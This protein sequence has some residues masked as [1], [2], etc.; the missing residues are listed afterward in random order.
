[1]TLIRKVVGAGTKAAKGAA[2]PNSQRATSI[3]ATENG[4]EP[5][6]GVASQASSHIFSNTYP[7]KHEH[8]LPDRLGRVATDWVSANPGTAACLAGAGIGVTLIAA[9]MAI[10]LPVLGAVGFGSGGI[11]G[12]S[13]AA[14]AMGSGVA[15]GSAF[16]TLQSAAMGGYGVAA[17][18]GAVQGT[19][20]AVAG[21]SGGLATWLRRKKAA[22]EEA[23]EEDEAHPES[24][25][26]EPVK[27]RL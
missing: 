6:Q 24:S 7:P 27:T 19:G 13:V 17:V 23:V 20:V 18:M 12:G 16:A 26:D 15:A 3:T 1:M 2:L 22:E 4:Q 10:A 25:E 8:I 5:A 11:V 14:G 9:P 21:A